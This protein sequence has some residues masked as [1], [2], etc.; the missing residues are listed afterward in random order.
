MDKVIPSK[1]AA[2]ARINEFLNHGEV[3]VLIGVVGKPGSGKSTFTKYLR[4]KSDTSQISV[5]PMDGFHLSNK[6]LK[7]LGRSD[8]KGA[9]DTFDVE[10]FINLLERIRTNTESEVYYPIFE[11]SMEESI[12][13]AG[14][15]SL[16]TKVV[17]I[18]GNYLLHKKDGW[19]KVQDLL[20]EVWMIDI[21][22]DKRIARLISRHIAFGKDPESAKAWAKG[23][24]E[25]N[26]QLI[27]EN[28]YR[29]NFIVKSD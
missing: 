19:E 12:A 11:R 17:I 9:P 20:D 1:Q 28:A 25:K 2:L 13:A 24:D 22:D 26:A 6:V 16:E 4:N 23:S 27:E 8:R 18:E 29:A 7:D 21:D 15:V 3:R 5:V 14:V 10:G